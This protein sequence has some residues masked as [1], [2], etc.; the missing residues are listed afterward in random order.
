MYNQ[1][2]PDDA[3]DVSDEDVSQIENDVLP[4]NVDIVKAKPLTVVNQEI[5]QV[6]T[7]TFTFAQVIDEKIP[8]HPDCN[9]KPC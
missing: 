7:P 1:D 6:N 2:Q 4:H 9:K 5:P 8:A 3:T